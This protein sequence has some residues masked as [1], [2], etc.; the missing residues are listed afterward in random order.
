[1]SADRELTLTR[2]FDAPRDLVFRAWTEP[3]LFLGWIGPEGCTGDTADFDVV[4]GGAWRATMLDQDGG[5][6]GMYGQY[7]EIAA[8]ERLAFTFVWDDE[9]AHLDRSRITLTFTDLDGKTE[10]TFHQTGFT[11]ATQRDDHGV[12]WTEAFDKIAPLLAR[13]TR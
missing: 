3:E 9:E 6:H 11:S 2:I 5:K 1:M 10:M 13:S 8:P 4:P 12:G 7:T